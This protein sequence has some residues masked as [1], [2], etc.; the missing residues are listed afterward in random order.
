MRRPHKYGA[1]PVVIDGIRFP[2]KA[3]GERYAQLKL[4]QKAGEI[5]HLAVQP[6][7]DL[8][9]NGVKCGFYKADFSYHVQDA[10]MSIGVV[11]DVKGRD[12][13]VSILKRKI[14][15][16]LYGVEIRLVTGKGALI[17]KKKGRR[18]A[19]DEPAQAPA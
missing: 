16:A 8:V 3:E 2:S 10:E 14:V 15:T 1:T 5:Y 7:F 13:P 9:I 19:N 6:R 17:T 11:E 18:R 4:L 12:T